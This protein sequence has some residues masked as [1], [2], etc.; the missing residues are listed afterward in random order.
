M[1]KP[2]QKI[3]ESNP[4]INQK[5]DKVEF[6]S[7]IQSWGLEVKLKRESSCLAS[8]KPRV[9]TPVWPK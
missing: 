8:V 9:E 4:A 7:K 3:N 5:G 1:Q 2:K 6:T